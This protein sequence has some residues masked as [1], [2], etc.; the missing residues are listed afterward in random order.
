MERAEKPVMKDPKKRKEVTCCDIQDKR[1][2]G[3]NEKIQ[4]LPRMQRPQVTGGAKEQETQP[5]K[6]KRPWR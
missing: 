4:D 2:W 1:N 3:V 5:R 6:K